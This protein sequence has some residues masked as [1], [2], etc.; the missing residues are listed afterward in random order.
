MSA[1]PFF[2][3]FYPPSINEDC[4]KIAFCTRMNFFPEWPSSDNIFHDGSYS[5]SLYYP[6]YIDISVLLDAIGI[7]STRES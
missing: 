5:S 1:P 4:E 6:T 3:S 2:Q 7:S